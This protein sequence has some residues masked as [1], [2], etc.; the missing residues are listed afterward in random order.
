MFIVTSFLE[1]LVREIKFMERIVETTFG[2][3]SILGHNTARDGI[4]E[5]EID[6]QKA[7][8]Q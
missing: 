7:I 5:A 3:V 8:R 1:R 2:T 4:S 6:T